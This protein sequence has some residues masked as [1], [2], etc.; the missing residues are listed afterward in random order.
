MSNGTVKVKSSKKLDRKTFRDL[1]EVI[2]KTSRIERSRETHPGYAY[3]APKEITI[4]LTCRCNLRCRH[5]FQWNDYGYLKKDSNIAELDPGVV[6]KILK[7]SHKEKSALYIWGGEPLFHNDWDAIARL[8]EKDLRRTIVSTNGLLLEK[9]LESILR[10]SPSLVIVISLDGLQEEHDAIRG[11]GT[12]N[13]TV[14]NIKLF[15]SLRRRQ[16]YKGTITINC[17]LNDYIVPKLFE[18]VEY[19]ESLGIDKLILGFPWYI[20]K[21]TAQ[22][23]D[24]YFTAN[25]S[26]LN[27][28]RGTSKPSWYS[29]SHH[30]ALPMIEILHEQIRKLNSHV[31]NTSVKFHPIMRLDE[32]KRIVIGKGRLKEQHCLGLSS[33]ISIWADGNTSFCSNFPEFEIGDINKQG[34][35][36][37]W[38]SDK[39]RRVREIMNT[40]SMPI[41]CQRCR[42]LSFNPM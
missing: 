14:E 30:L 31:W 26:W 5:C 16:E 32:I 21:E 3:V 24:D 15:V 22:S 4:Q 8:I 37:I 19:C 12:F 18:F 41:S 33:R 40:K 23:M 29:F 34:M 28:L 36:E 39:F 42:Q 17:T 35:M 13:R 27:S 20:T 9:R 25:L 7:E 1:K 6:E 11:L 2:E 38:Q 10:I